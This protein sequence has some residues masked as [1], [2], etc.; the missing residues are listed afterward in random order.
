MNDH[1]QRCR[2][3]QVWMTPDRRGH[4]PQYGSSSYEPSGRHNQLLH[5]LSGVGP[6]PTWQNI[7]SRGTIQ[8][9]ADANV[10][11]S[12][13]DGGVKYQLELGP[14]RQAYLV[15]MEGE[16]PGGQP[17]GSSDSRMA[18]MIHQYACP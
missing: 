15:C 5:V 18:A 12:E 6:A 8:L 9:H 3:L 16:G 17:V 10:F 7:N 4:T 11:V 2:F 14:S 13:N 1:E